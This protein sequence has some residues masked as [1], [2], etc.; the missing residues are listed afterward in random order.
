MGL[1]VLTIGVGI[2]YVVYFLLA[3]VANRPPPLPPVHNATMGAVRFF[4]LIQ[5]IGL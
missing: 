2:A 1:S 3:L 4:C 5:W